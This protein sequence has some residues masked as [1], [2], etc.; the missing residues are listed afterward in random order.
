MQIDTRNRE[1]GITPD[2]IFNSKACPVT[3]EKS[4]WV[5]Y[6]PKQ[7]RY[8]FYNDTTSSLDPKVRAKMNFRA[9]GILEC[10]CNSRYA[11]DPSI[12]GAD[13]L[14]KNDKPIYSIKTTSPTCG[15]DEVLDAESCFAGAA[16]LMDGDM[17]TGGASPVSRVVENVTVSEHDS[18][19]YPL[20]CTIKLVKT[21]ETL[22]FGQLKR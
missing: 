16:A 20:G 8:G 22:Q 18:T 10:P 15:T 11:G 9:A 19:K 5:G 2:D 14:T 17:S 7:A 13:T 6:E 3:K 4:F 21:G 1:C 12:Y